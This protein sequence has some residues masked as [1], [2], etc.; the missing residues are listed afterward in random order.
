M[1]RS[2]IDSLCVSRMTFAKS[3]VF[4]GITSALFSVEKKILKK[5]NWRRRTIGKYFIEYLTSSSIQKR[6]EDGKFFCSK[7]YLVLYYSSV[8]Y[9]V[10][11][12]LISI[13]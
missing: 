4:E 6:A 10:F 1:I 2:R 9:Y 12:F 8:F 3:L 11:S 13:M 5:L 7:M